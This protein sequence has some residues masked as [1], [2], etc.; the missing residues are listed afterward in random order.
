MQLCKRTISNGGLMVIDMTTR[1]GV[2]LLSAHGHVLQD[3]LYI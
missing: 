2:K 3:S 1:G